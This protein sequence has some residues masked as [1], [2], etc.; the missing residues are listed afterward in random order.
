VLAARC[1]ENM[2]DETFSQFVSWLVE[3]R[4]PMRDDD[5]NFLIG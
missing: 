1:P 3:T 5:G 4:E 2:E